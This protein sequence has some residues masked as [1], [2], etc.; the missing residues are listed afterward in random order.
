MSLF[1]IVSLIISLVALFGYLNYRFVKLPEP[2]G[3][4]AV[5][6]VASIAVAVVGALDPQLTAWARIAVQNIDF[7]AVVF[8]GLLGLLLF[9][10]SLHVNWDDIRGEIWIIAVLATVGVLL[11]TVIVGAGLYFVA[12]WLGFPLPMIQCL[13]F[14]AL[15]SPTDP[16]A[17]LGLLK[18]LGVSKE[19]ETKI[20]GESLFNDGTGV[21]VFITLLGLSSGEMP[22]SASS[23]TLL[24]LTEVAG[25]VFVGLAIG[26]LGVLMLKAVDSYAVE[27]L[28]TLAMA[29]GGYAL[30]DALHT[31]APIAVVLM[32]LIVGNQGKRLAMSEETRHHLFSFWKLVDELLNLVLFGLIGIEFIALS[33]SASALFPGLVAILLV[34]LARWISVGLPVAAMRPFQHFAP[35]TITILTWGGLRGGISIALALSL[36]SVQGR[37][38]I[39]AA[40]YGV[41][42]F[43]ILVQ[44][45][46]LRPLIRRLRP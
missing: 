9:A 25:G 45:L 42:I 41:V 32:G 36:P 19:L 3:I 22:V 12:P 27:I 34:L 14:G 33:L 26:T 44:A 20:A 15:I 18:S 46:T 39:L 17:V 30:A 40:T 43:S 16:I 21:V 37:E 8:Q 6:L 2:V 10:G 5:G 1:H 23:V 35:H 29:T 7:T 31:S 24:L 13:M 28:I 4:T 38:I 11:S